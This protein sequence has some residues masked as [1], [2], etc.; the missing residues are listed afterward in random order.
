MASGIES[1]SVAA[2]TAPKTQPGTAV[3]LRASTKPTQTANPT[4]VLGC[5]NLRIP[6]YARPRHFGPI[7]N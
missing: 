2:T 6:A 5:M 7:P 3:A 1:T 4:S